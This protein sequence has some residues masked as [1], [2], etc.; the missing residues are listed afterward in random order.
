[1]FKKFFIEKGFQDK[2][3]FGTSQTIHPTDKILKF[4][5]N[6]NVVQVSLVKINNT[7]YKP[8]LAFYLHDN[9][10]DDP[11][12]GLIT[13]I[14]RLRK[15]TVI[16]VYKECHTIGFYNHMKGYI[17]TLPNAFQPEKCFQAS[18]KEFVK[19]IKIHVTA[20]GKN[21]ICRR[22]IR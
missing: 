16:L 13:R 14:L 8:N 12:F 2:I 4:F 10:N 18:L 19:P 15:S 9:E 17:L 5:K 7:L 20:E 1:M 6:D 3:E 11:V 21:I 22:D